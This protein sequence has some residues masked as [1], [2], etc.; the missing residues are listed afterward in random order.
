MKKGK[1]R[2]VRKKYL[3][4]RP[5]YQD[6]YCII[7]FDQYNLWDGNISEMEEGDKMIV[8]VVEMT[9]AEMDALPEFEGW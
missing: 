9:D 6:A 5:S 1:A 3:K 2:G 4:L 7:E 8:E